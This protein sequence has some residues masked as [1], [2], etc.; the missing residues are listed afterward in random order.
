M[1]EMMDKHVKD[2]C[3]ELK[4]LLAKYDLTLEVD[5]QGDTHGIDSE[6]FVVSDRKGKTT[7]IKPHYSYLDASDL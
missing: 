4:A 1:E 7:I 3:K 2:F 6:D 5:I